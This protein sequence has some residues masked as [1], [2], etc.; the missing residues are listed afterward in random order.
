[1]L[2]A[3][4]LAAGNSSRMGKPKA[5]LELKGRTFIE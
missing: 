3:I 1:M 5:I 2:S 4:L